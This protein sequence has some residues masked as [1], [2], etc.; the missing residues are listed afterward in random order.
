V[1]SRTLDAIDTS[2]AWVEDTKARTECWFKA[3]FS[4]G[5]LASYSEERLTLTVS[6]TGRLRE[7]VRQLAVAKIRRTLIE[8]GVDGPFVQGDGLGW[9]IEQNGQCP[10]RLADLPDTGKVRTPAFDD[11]EL[12]AAHYDPVRHRGPA[13]RR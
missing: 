3:H 10:T 2:F 9:Q 8:D 7:R 4:W 11:D 6:F 1:R 5:Y 12:A 13:P